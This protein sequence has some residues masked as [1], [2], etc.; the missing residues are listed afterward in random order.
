MRLRWRGLNLL[1]TKVIEEADEV[2]DDVENSIGRGRYRRV[3]IT[4]A[5][6][7]GCDGMIAVVSQV[8][9]LVAPREPEFREAVKEEY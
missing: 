9:D 5:S 7:I 8:G 4:K 6:Q 2:A 3:W 1:L